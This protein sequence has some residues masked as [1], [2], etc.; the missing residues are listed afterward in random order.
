MISLPI[1]EKIGLTFPG[2]AIFKTVRLRAVPA[3]RM[4]KSDK[5]E[6][7]P[8]VMRYRGYSTDLRLLYD[9]A[10]AI[11]LEH[12]FSFADGLEI[13]FHMKT[14]D[15]RL[16]GFGHPLVPDGDNLVKAI[17]DSLVKAD[18]SIYAW[19]AFKYWDKEDFIEIGLHNPRC[20][21]K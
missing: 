12:P 3:P 5:W 20:L 14:K 4:S 16:W 7:R 19:F 15:K 9:Q 21:V 2:Q 13:I 1:F 10:K 11:R 18:G 8:S 17:S 6:K